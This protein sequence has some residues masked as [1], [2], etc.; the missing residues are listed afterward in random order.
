MNAIF[1]MNM[2][3][4]DSRVM[5]YVLCAMIYAITAMFVW[6]SRVEG[7]RKHLLLG[8]CLITSAWAVSEA[9]GS[10]WPFGL[11]LEIAR[12][13]VWLLFF[14]T[15]F[16]RVEALAKWLPPSL[17]RPGCVALVLIACPGAGVLFYLIGAPYSHTLF[18]YLQILI[19]V[20]TLLSIENIIRNIESRSDI[21]WR[22]FCSGA[23]LLAIFDVFFFSSYLVSEQVDVRFFVVRS[24][25]FSFGGPLLIFATLSG[26]G[27]QGKLS[28]SRRA[29]F[30]STALVGAGVYLLLTS[31][32]GEM[33]RIRSG[34]WGLTFE[35]TFLA[36]AV[37]VLAMLLESAS[38]RARVMVFI[39]KHFFR[40]KYDYREVWLEFIRKMAAPEEHESLHD[41]ALQAVGGAIG[42][43]S[44]VLW[45]LQPAIESYAPVACWNMTDDLPTIPVD[46]KVTMFMGQTGWIIGINQC[47]RD[48]DFYGGLILPSWMG[49]LKQA[50]VVVP[51]IHLRVLEAFVVLGHPAVASTRLGWEDLDLLKTVG[52]QAASYLAEERASREL[53]D[54]RRLAEFNRRFAFVVHDIKNVVS[55]MA[56]MLENAERF[57]GDP[58]FQKD[59]LVTVASSVD[60]LRRMLVNLGGE[61]GSK[62]GRMQP[63]WLTDLVAAAV[64]RWRRSFP[65]LAYRC[66]V[67]RIEVTGWAERL[68]SALDHLVQNAIEATGQGGRV[69][70]ILSATANEA[71]IEIVDDG[72][73]MSP[74]FIRDQLFRPLATSKPNGSGI[75]AFQALKI[76]RDMEG[77][78]EVD[79]C[80][81]VGT[82]VKIRLPRKVAEL[83]STQEA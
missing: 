83:C 75:G 74:E 17:R 25:V 67:E 7:G 20:V 61:A 9:F 77:L 21:G 54:G 28:L 19:N 37:I 45:A 10:A 73:G 11:Q 39:S 18:A 13:S 22:V 23:S 53:L 15:S 60:R 1:S 42:C 41:R 27:G 46:H 35:L 56:M 43:R 16:G 49:E 40:L 5:G 76:V 55:Q 8:G 6:R 38:I 68:N 34:N 80:L 57:G 32:G 70:I 26:W 24:Y 51:L 31:V 14:A 12:S 82:T 62:H 3:A 59:M 2:D 71:V 64:H 79:S 72:P 52:A 65:S 66:D 30:H 48:P 58:E 4:L 44:G 47:M 50:W 33:L 78:L 69:E 81:N 29:V 63:L 36:A